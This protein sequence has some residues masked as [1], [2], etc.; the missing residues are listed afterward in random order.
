MNISGKKIKSL[1][2]K[3]CH[4]ED[5]LFDCL[6]PPLTGIL[7]LLFILGPILST[8]VL[9]EITTLGSLRPS[10]SCPL[11]E[12]PGRRLPGNGL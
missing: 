8:L 3:H 7:L 6:D 1:T 2:R 10:S 12:L 9:V 11:K 4:E 5:H